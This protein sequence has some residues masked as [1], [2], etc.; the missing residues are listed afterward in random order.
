MGDLIYGEQIFS[1]KIT[2]S[3]FN[4]LSIEGVKSVTTIIQNLKDRIIFP[5]ITILILNSRFELVYLY[6]EQKV[7]FKTLTSDIKI[8]SILI[9]EITLINEAK[10]LIECILNEIIA[11][12]VINDYSIEVLALKYKEFFKNS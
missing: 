4:F 6:D 12:D 8:D 1:R 3:I 11:T 5:E 7:V 2:R 10:H 9:E